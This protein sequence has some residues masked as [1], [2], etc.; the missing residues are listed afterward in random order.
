MKVINLFYLMMQSEKY[1]SFIEIFVSSFFIMSFF[2]MDNNAY[3]ILF[4]S[5]SIFS[6]FLILIYYFLYK[7]I[8]DDI[9]IKYFTLIF[10]LFLLIFV[11]CFIGVENKNIINRIFPLLSLFGII[12]IGG[13]EFENNRKHIIQN[14]TKI[15]IGLSL[16]MNIDFILFLL[17]KKTYIWEPV[18]YLGYRCQGP[19]FDP[20]FL[21]LYAT[22]F[23]LIIYYSENNY[24]NLKNKKIA[25]VTVFLN[26][27]FSGSFS[28]FIFLPLTIILHKINIIKNLKNNRKK[29]II[30]LLFYFISIFF[31][32][33]FYEEISKYLILILK[34]IYNDL[35]SATIKFRS[36]DLR[37]MTQ[38]KALK[39]IY[40]EWWGKGPRQLVP[41]LGMDTHNSYVGIAFEQG[42]IGFFILYVSLIKNCQNII[43]RYVGT[44]LMLSAL[45]INVH[46]LPLYSLFLMIQFL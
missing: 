26:I 38:T 21:A 32:N 14:I 42:I 30:I 13:K 2:Y 39:L 3:K 1:K 4:Y 6:Q 12:I 11:F 45:L 20:N 15:F 19:F 8:K 24:L 22:T 33:I 17:S 36:L 23:F 7:K 18:G 27:F 10:L 9:L 34:E 5:L 31:Y 37:I 35:E 28:T 16:V 40:L 46:L 41:F 43:G 25:L 44:Y 29:M